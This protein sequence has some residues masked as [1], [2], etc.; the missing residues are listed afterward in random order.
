MK[1]MI[2]TVVRPSFWMKQIVHFNG[3]SDDEKS[4]ENT[5]DIFCTEIGCKNVLMNFVSMFMRD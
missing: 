5:N 3:E 4:L 2:S 1:V